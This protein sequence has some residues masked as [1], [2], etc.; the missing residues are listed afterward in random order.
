M[1]QHIICPNSDQNSCILAACNNMYKW[2]QRMKL[3]LL[4]FLFIQYPL[5]FVTN[6]TCNLSEAIKGILVVNVTYN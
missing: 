1:W 5:S 4:I 6:I 3:Y 2:S